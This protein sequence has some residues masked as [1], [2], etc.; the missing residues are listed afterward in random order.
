M[1]HFSHRYIP[2]IHYVL[3]TNISKVFPTEVTQEHRI[4][5]P[6]TEETCSPM[7]IAALFT[8]VKEWSQ[9]RCLSTD[10]QIMKMQCIHT[11]GSYSAEKTNE[12]L[13]KGL[14]LVQKTFK[15]LR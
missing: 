3:S 13:T 11:M 6:V 7:I 9:P 1:G 2:Q 12:N 8:V 10:E 14:S 4:L 15:L 5:Y